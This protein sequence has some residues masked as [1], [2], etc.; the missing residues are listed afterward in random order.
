MGLKSIYVY[1]DSCLV[2]YLIEEHPI[3]APLLE[4]YIST[5][6]DLIFVV[7]DLSEMECFVMPFR[8]NNQLLINKFSAWFR[9]AKSV[10]LSKKVFNQAAH[11]RA[12][13]P[14]LKTPDALHL[15]TA[16]HHNCDEF[17]TN[18][19]RLDKVAPNLIKSVLTI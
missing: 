18:D 3:F 1:L 9:K 5:R 15:A 10:S 19:T 17:W 12:D 14:S 7:S 11:L 8:K 16:I 4:S 13:F 6:F 2:I